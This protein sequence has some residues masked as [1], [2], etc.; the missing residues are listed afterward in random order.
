[1]SYQ[2]SGNPA[3]R[4]NTSD[5]RSVSSSRPQIAPTTTTTMIAVTATR[6]PDDA[7]PRPM[8]S[9]TACP[10]ACCKCRFSAGVPTLGRCWE[11][12]GLR[13]LLPLLPI[14]LHAPGRRHDRADQPQQGEDDPDDEH[15]P[16][17]LADAH[18]AQRHDEH[19]PE[20]PVTDAPDHDGVLPGPR[21]PPCT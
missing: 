13:A 15:D 16:V 20:N 18:H 3:R 17:T 14:R 11:C 6:V 9:R 5:Q 2:S 12:F 8:L 4:W 19:Q 7:P 21:L 10:S 1:M